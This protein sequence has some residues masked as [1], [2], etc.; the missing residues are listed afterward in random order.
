MGHFFLWI[1]ETQASFQIFG[2]LPE[3]RDKLKRSERK[4]KRLGK[5]FETSIVYKIRSKSFANRK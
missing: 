3:R 1:G 5:F 4:S 2:T